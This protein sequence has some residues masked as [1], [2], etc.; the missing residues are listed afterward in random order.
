MQL[1]PPLLGVIPMMVGKYFIH[2]LPLEKGKMAFQK[3]TEKQKK[4]LDISRG[5]FM[6]KNNY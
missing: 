6:V 5:F 4:P 2:H 1:E 3:E